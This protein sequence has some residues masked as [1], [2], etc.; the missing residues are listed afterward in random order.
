[1]AGF[2]RADGRKGIRNVVAVA[3]MVESVYFVAREISPTFRDQAV[4][5]IGFPGCCPNAYTDKMIHQL[6]EIV[7]LVRAVSNGQMP[8]GESLGH[9]ESILTCKS[10]DPIGPARL[11]IHARH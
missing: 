7:A 2:A 8:A 6:D 3:C 11:P 5:L 4:H 9:Q 1:M 10:F